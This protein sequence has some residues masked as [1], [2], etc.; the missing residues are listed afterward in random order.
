MALAID[1]RPRT[2]KD[3]A[4]N[5]SVKKSLTAMFKR[6]IKDIPHCYLFSGLSGGGKT[7]LAGILSNHLK[8]NKNEYYEINSA[9]FNGVDDVRSLEKIV[10][11]KPMSGNVRVWVFNEVHRWTGAAQDALLDMME[12]KMPDHAY[13]ILTTTD[14]QKLIK[15]LRKRCIEYEVLPLTDDEMFDYL[16][17]IVEEENANVPDEILDKI[18]KVAQG[19][20]R[21]ALQLLEKVIDLTPVEMNKAA[22]KLERNETITKDLIDALLKK[23]SW[24]KVAA[25]LKNLTI[26]P[27]TVR[28][29]VMG[30]CSAILLNGKDNK[31]AALILDCFKSN[32]YDS[33]KNGLLLACYEVVLK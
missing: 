8:C 11:Y 23:E 15:P 7:T 33:G 3:L 17:G 13:F 12:E 4:G 2:F 5:E 28:W 22:L 16:V 6:P 27:E 21:N 18:I 19:S 20:C 32:F 24:S 10:R 29:N 25:I 31:Q 26:E 14:P 30:Y 9:H 1:H